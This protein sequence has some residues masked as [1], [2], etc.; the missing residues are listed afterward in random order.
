MLI[1]RAKKSTRTASHQARDCLFSVGA[2]LLGVVVSGVSKRNGRYGY[3]GDY[4]YYR[5]R[6]SHGQDHRKVEKVSNKKPAAV[7]EEV[8]T[9]GA[10]E[11]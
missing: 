2:H 11:D 9:D 6:G 7:M 10:S 3:N 4:R 8:D 5:S 1:L